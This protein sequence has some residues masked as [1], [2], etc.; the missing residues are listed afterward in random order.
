[1]LRITNFLHYYFLEYFLKR[2]E[3]IFYFLTFLSIFVFFFISISFRCFSKNSSSR[4][5][6]YKDIKE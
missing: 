2:Q 1:M 5:R 3:N 6:S 4:P